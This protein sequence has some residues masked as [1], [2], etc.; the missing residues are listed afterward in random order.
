MTNAVNGHGRKR[1]LS[2]AVEKPTAVRR[3]ANA[4]LHPFR[5][6]FVEDVY[7]ICTCIPTSLVAF[8]RKLLLKVKDDS[9]PAEIPKG[10]GTALEDIPNVAEKL[11]R[12]TRNSP[13]VGLLH[14]LVFGGKAKVHARAL[15][16][17]GGQAC[18]KPLRKQRETASR[19]PLSCVSA[20]SNTRV[21]RRPCACCLSCFV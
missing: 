7:L 3:T 5:P 15:G 17:E 2:A 13:L 4:Q 11:G 1:P 9:K 20:P 19:S 14:N 10:K 12:L 21:S 6:P 18:T 8:S 16:V